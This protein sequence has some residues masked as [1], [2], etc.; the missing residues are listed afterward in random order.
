MTT[1]WVDARAR[2]A[3][4]L[5]RSRAGLQA[6]AAPWRVAAVALALAALGAAMD[7]A[8]A[9]VLRRDAVML[10]SARVALFVISWCLALAAAHTADRA[11]STS[12]LSP[13][14]LGA[15]GLTA[16]W[17]AL[18][19]LTAPLIMSASHPEPSAMPAA[20]RAVEADGVD[21]SFMTHS[22][23]PPPTTPLTR[24]GP[25]LAVSA[26]RKLRW[27]DRDGVQPV[28]PTDRFPHTTHV[29]MDYR[30]S[31]ADFVAVADVAIASGALEV[32]WVLPREEWPVGQE[33]RPSCT[34]THYGLQAAMTDPVTQGPMTVHAVAEPAHATPGVPWTDELGPFAETEL[35][36]VL[37]RGLSVRLQRW[38]PADAGR[39][40]GTVMAQRLLVGL[41][42]GLA[43]FLL[44]LVRTATAAHRLT[45]A[46]DARPR[47]AGQ[48]CGA[49]A[50]LPTWLP[51]RAATH[52]VGGG[53]PYRVAPGL[54][55]APL[56]VVLRM[57]VL[58]VR[59]ALVALMAAML[60][61]SATLLVA[62]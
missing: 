37:E 39:T 62:G 40:T 34:P 11:L 36:D 32:A 13:T 46:A 8:H 31:V 6:N 55:T 45:R 24:N 9:T 2:I 57:G 35:Y 60:V 54:L 48:P 50:T 18:A 52:G 42:L 51:R 22:A 29:L 12:L 28:T 47:E 10:L 38:S 1:R 59:G 16:A 14:P 53:A 3:L 33:Y 5:R 20:T 58:R 25:L 44:R 26:G 41:A 49:V 27:V 19:V 30:A 43:L 23:P 15:A 17:V 7:A 56:G 4:A 61:L 21:F